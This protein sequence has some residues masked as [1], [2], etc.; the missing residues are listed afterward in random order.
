MRLIERNSVYCLTGITDAWHG[1]LKARNLGLPDPLSRSLV[2]VCALTVGVCVLTRESGADLRGSVDAI[3][4]CHVSEITKIH[5]SRQKV[6]L[7]GSVNLL[8]LGSY[9]EPLRTT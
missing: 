9:S 5:Y 1:H 4:V 3:V 2:L 7:R 8:V 6:S